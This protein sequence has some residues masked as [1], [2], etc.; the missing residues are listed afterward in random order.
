MLGGHPSAEQGYRST[1]IPLEGAAVL[2]GWMEIQV[3]RIARQIHMHRVLRFNQ[4]RTGTLRTETLNLYLLPG[5]WNFQVLGFLEDAFPN[6]IFRLG[7]VGAHPRFRLN[8]IF[9]L[10]IGKERRYQHGA[11]VD[12]GRD[13]DET[14]NQLYINP[15]PPRLLPD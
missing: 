15:Y 1:T 6:G 4:H 5:D 7:A 8:S 12:H 3:E 11:A 9:E 10:I 14:N 13:D 2:G